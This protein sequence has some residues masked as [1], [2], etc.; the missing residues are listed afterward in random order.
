LRLARS[1]ADAIV[2]DSSSPTWMATKFHG[3]WRQT[4]PPERFR[5]FWSPSCAACSATA[6]P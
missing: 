2:L 3:S 6:C 5:S 4:R 1:Q